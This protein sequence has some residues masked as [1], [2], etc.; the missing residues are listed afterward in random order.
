MTETTNPAPETTEAPENTGT[1][2][3]LVNAEVPEAPQ[4]KMRNS[5]E[6]DEDGAFDGD[7]DDVEVIG[8]DQSSW[9]KIGSGFYRSD[10]IVSVE[11]VEKPSL[12]TPHIN[13]CFA[14]QATGIFFPDCETPLLTVETIM[15]RIIRAETCD[16][17]DESEN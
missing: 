16:D 11:F 10:E 15:E 14:R 6:F 12:G 13:V 2:A 8:T 9:I 5:A 1:V 4:R 17:D 7:F 3:P